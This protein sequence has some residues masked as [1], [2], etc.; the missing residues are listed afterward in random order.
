MIKKI[1]LDKADRL[2]HF[3]FDLEDFIPKRGIKSGEKKIPTI[4][5]ARF[6]WN[7]PYP[8]GDSFHDSAIAG[9]DDI[10]ILK[11]K[12]AD[13]LQDEY[14]IKVNPR[15]E[16]YIGQGIHRIILDMILS[17]VEFGDVV[18]CPEPGMPF[19]KRLVIAA[20]GAPVTYPVFTRADYKPSL[21]KVDSNLG[22]AAKI[23]ILNNPNNPVGIIN[24]STELAEIIS[25]ASKQNLFLINDAAYCSLAE[26]KFTPLHSIPGGSK[27]GL[28]VFS[29]PYTF[30]MPY[31]PFGFAIGPADIISAMES[32]SKTVKP[33]ILRGW[34]RL[35][36][37]TIEKYPA[38][39][40]TEMNKKIDR[41]RLA[42]DRFINQAEWEKVGGKSC[43][44][45]WVRI[46]D[47]K[48]S[49]SYASALLRRRRLATLPGNA[50][51]ETCDGFLRL[52]LTA[53][54]ESYDEAQK[55]ML[56]KFPLLT[57]Q[58]DE[59]PEEDE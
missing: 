43:P 28:E 20:G 50:F 35:A 37:D 59:I 23:M 29:F 7:V 13:W 30:G 46:P 56:K 32:I 15:R 6:N 45:V 40:L 38:A 36:I 12:L 33:V 58:D 4:D 19:Y 41:A 24:D 31:I 57:R 10:D 39:S 9:H 18:L 54:E 3:P 17:F 34:I 42:A 53:S 47:R 25:I 16:I 52:S 21:S 5:L 26:E 44:F 48:H 27:V 51:G 2:Y 22:K 14:S 8:E 49:A 55:R 1:I 11:E